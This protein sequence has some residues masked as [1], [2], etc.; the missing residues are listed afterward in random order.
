[1]DR[2]EAPEFTLTT[3]NG[4]FRN[5]QLQLSQAPRN[6]FQFITWDGIQIRFYGDTAVVTFH[7]VRKSKGS[8]S[9]QL[10]VLAVY[11]KRDGQWTVVAQQGTQTV[12]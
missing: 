2:I 8:D 7:V 6:Q 10:R 1:M 11:V 3:P 5:K 4:V 12:Q 9:E